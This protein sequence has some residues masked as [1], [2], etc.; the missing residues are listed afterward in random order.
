MAKVRKGLLKMIRNSL[1]SKVLKET[2]LKFRKFLNKHRIKELIFPMEEWID[3]QFVESS[4]NEI[5]EGVSVSMIG[6]PRDNEFE[7]VPP[8]KYRLYSLGSCG[9]GI[10]KYFII[11]DPKG[12]ETTFVLYSSDG[13]IRKAELPE[14]K[15]AEIKKEILG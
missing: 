15:I 11:K 13:R 6:E 14:A 9:S 7:W 10:K 1:K 2:L 12:K 4:M 3:S 8:K 5:V